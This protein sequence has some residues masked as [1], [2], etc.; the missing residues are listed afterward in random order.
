MVQLYLWAYKMK[1]WDVFYKLLLSFCEGQIRLYIKCGT[2]AEN[3]RC[4]SNSNPSYLNVE[5]SL[6]V[7]WCHDFL[8]FLLPYHWWKDNAECHNTSLRWVG[9]GVTGWGTRCT[10]VLGISR[11]FSVTSS[12]TPKFDLFCMFCFVWI[13]SI[14]WCF[15]CNRFETWFVRHT[16]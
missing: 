10:A 11:T 14:T 13:K 16:F 9:L 4:A 8:H 6:V 1:L 7:C 2:A 5:F 15:L 12:V 3:G